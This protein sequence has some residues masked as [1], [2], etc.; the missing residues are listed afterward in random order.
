MADAFEL[1]ARAMAIFAHP[2]D[3][4]FGCSG[5]LSLWADRGVHVAY[6]L[7]TNGDKGTHDATMA[8]AR[9]ARTRE[10]EQRAAG[11]IV[12]VRD[13]VFLRNH[14][15]ELEISMKLRAAVCRAIRQHRPDVVFTQD[16]WR[17]YQM[18]PDHRVAGWAA[19]DGI[20]AA[21]DHLFFREQLRGKL[22]H[23]RVRRVYLFGTSEPNIWFD[24]SATLERKIAAIAA[25]TSQIRDVK[26]L[27]Q[28]MRAFA[29]ATGG[30]WGLEAAEGFRYLE[31]G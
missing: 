6:C 20:I 18:H 9:L 19:L 7:L 24:I 13:Y 27:S 30:A 2:D 17:T 11:G 16:P 3:A 26:A 5:T 10:R 25:H 28:R 15:G 1:P 4:E 8:P 22:T 21:R 29:G 12:G 14:D 23:H 31:L